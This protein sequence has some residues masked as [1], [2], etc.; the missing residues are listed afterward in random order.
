MTPD[1]RGSSHP[2]KSPPSASG[3]DGLDWG[4]RA[5]EL[6]AE[7]EGA[8]SLSQRVDLLCRVAEIYERRLSD[9]SSALMT[10]QVALEQEPSSGRVVQEIERLARGNGAWSQAIAVAAEVAGT[11]TDPRQAADLWVQIAYWTDNGLAKL[12]DAA[13]AARAA[14]AV[15]P[16]HGGAL[17]VLE[18]LYRRQRS[19]DAYVEI[20]GR[21]HDAPGSDPYRLLEPYREVLRYEPQHPGALDGLARLLESTGDWGSAA[22]AL[23]QLIAGLEKVGERV[24]GVQ[25]G[26]LAA[27]HRLG[28][29][30][31]DRL[32]DE[33]GAEEQLVLTLASSGGEGH[34]PTLLALADIYRARRDWLKARQLV[35][36]AAAA[37]SDPYQRVLHL[38]D[39]A[40][41]CAG[42]LDDEAQA[43]ELYGEILAADP[44]R[45][46]VVDKLAAIRFKRGDW[47]G[48]LPLAAQL[49]ATLV[50][51][52]VP[53]ERARL[54]FQ[55]G[56]ALRETGDQAGALKAQKAAVAA[57]AEEPVEGEAVRAARRE[58]AALAFETE[59]WGD[60][61][62]AY[63]ALLAP[64]PGPHHDEDGGHAPHAAEGY[65]RL[66]IALRRQGEPARAVA[67]LEKAVAL[68]PRRKR[69]LEE[70]LVAA[71][72]AGDDEVVVRHT[73]GLLAVTDDKLTKRQLLETVAEIHRERRRDPQRAIAAYRAALEVWPEERSLMHRMLELLTET[74]QWKASVQVL[75]RLADLAEPAERNP[76]FVAAGNILAEELKLPVEAIEAYEQALDADPKDLKTFERIDKLV[77]AAR[78]WKTQTRSYR[79]QIK[80][81][82]TEVPPE[83]RPALL[84]LWHGLGEIYRTRLRDFAAAAAAFEVAVGLD[85]D[86][87]ERRKILAE[88]HR[89]SGRESYP[90]AIAQ[91][92]TLVA[93]APT[94]V[95]AIP[96]LKT[97]LRLFVALDWLDEGYA[98]AAALVQLGQADADERLWYERYRPKGVVRAYGRLTEELWQRLV[99]HPDQNRPLSQLLA[100]LCPALALAHAKDPKDVRIKKK[101]QRDVAND[102]SVACRVLAYGCAVFGMPAPE[103]YLAPEAA[104]PVEVV[105]LKG[106][107]AGQPALVLGRPLLETPSDIELAFTVGQ[108][109]AAIRPEHLARVPAFVSTPAELEVAVRAAVKLVDADRPVPKNIAAEV[110]RYAA[111]LS[112]AMPPQLREQVSV[113]VRRFGAAQTDASGGL[114]LPRWSRAAALTTLRAGLLLC[115]DL[116]V[117]IRLGTPLAAAAGI[118][119]FELLRE[120]AAWSVSEGYF[121]LRTALGL[122]VVSSS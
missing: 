55:L 12:D 85:P 110:D 50:D 4:A 23:R 58:L 91:H 106:T 14:L 104:A 17:A 93:R 41:I 115:G 79:R 83:Q 15:D 114:D 88:L 43:A 113:L 8:A 86:S 46:E 92:R 45:M 6:F 1:E 39:A 57:G 24:E 66:G 90:K 59:A 21:K 27:R 42:E 75:I 94:A 52:V 25:A 101:Q 36:R 29:L 108:T 74:K 54:F 19:W 80:R 49:A 16:E 56:R 48:L 89:L 10:L 103:V 78:D 20:L 84:A 26:L 60:A 73:Q 95:A 37:V 62:L 72:E 13:G 67:A 38:E 47:V 105:D 44:L 35:G 51:E 71:R 2:D 3:V 100:T 122:G 111:F 11:L 98:A 69:A 99:Y 32:G 96:D 81:M 117:A 64:G 31:K 22:E 61:A 119:A 65:E 33:R 107:V 7:A 120:L 9:T 118:D 53:A 121:E 112:K 70:L 77:T 34:V 82:G 97:L 30:L 116:E 18:E 76:Y 5:A 63:E 40:A 87:L 102:P 68:E 28:M 109:L